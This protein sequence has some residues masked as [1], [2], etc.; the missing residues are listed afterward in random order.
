VQIKHPEEGKTLVLR[1]LVVLLSIALL[2][3]GCATRK[4]PAETPE[5]APVEMPAPPASTRGR[6]TIEADKLD[7]WNA[8]GQIVVRTP[9]VEYEGR[10][11]ML[12]LYDVRYRQVPFLIL[13]KALLLSETIKKTTTAVTA[14]TPDGKPID[15]DAVA[16][17]LAL[18]QRE[19][20]AEIVSV[21]ARQ[22]EEARAKKAKA[23]KSKSKKKRKK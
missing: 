22:A 23:S 5:A 15:N 9:G 17:L 18:L 10:S 20:P 7:T 13:T 19:L 4:P 21:R 8:V 16:D 2:A 12:D 3:V 1:K 6:F 14:T 11:Q